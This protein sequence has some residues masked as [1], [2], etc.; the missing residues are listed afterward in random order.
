VSDVVPGFYWLIQD[1]LAGCGRPGG[2]QAPG[3]SRRAE[4]AW[5]QFDAVEQALAWL[6]RQ[7][8]GAVLSLTET[9][10]PAEVVARQ[11]L[12]MLHMPVPDLQAPTP[13]QFLHALAF[14]DRQRAQGRAVVVHCLVGQGRTGTVLAAYR[15]RGGATPQEALRT[16][17]ALC[18]GAIG[19]P[20]QEQALYAFASR[21]DWI[22]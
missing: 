17:R 6:R 13:D 4:Q 7:G 14:I 8:I 11:K 18:P 1:A 3:R 21:R 2:G 19:S 15:I 5:D 9:P 20:S 10:L 16:V 22:L 12:T